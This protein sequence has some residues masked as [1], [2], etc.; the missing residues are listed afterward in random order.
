[1]TQAPSQEGPFLGKSQTDQ[2]WRLLRK[3]AFANL[4]I[5]E[6]RVTA[7]PTSGHG[8]RYEESCAEGS[9][10]PRSVVGMSSVRHGDEYRR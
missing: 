4:D 9:L 10:C 5:R 7:N 6:G 2:Y 3:L 1:V 8:L